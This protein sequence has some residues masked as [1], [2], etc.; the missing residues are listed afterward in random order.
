[1][2]P[3]SVSAPIASSASE[4]GMNH[5]RA[6]DESG[7]KWDESSAG[8]SVRTLPILSVELF[9]LEFDWLIKAV[10][11]DTPGVR[12]G[13]G[14]IEAFD[15]AVATKEMI[16]R[17]RAEPITGE[18]SLLGDEFEILMRN[19]DVKKLSHRADRTIAAQGLNWRL[20]HFRNEPNRPTVAAPLNPHSLVSN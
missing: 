14:L 20:R 17:E 9:N 10:R 15:S 13:S 16:G 6:L 11:I 18:S 3:L 19:D 8:H 4:Q 5:A 7:R 12:M 2:H 1:V